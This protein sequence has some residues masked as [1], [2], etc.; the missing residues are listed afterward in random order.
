VNAF[1]E[2]LKKQGGCAWLL[3]AY[4]IFMVGYLIYWF[5][6]GGD[7]EVKQFRDRCT[8]RET[9]RYG[10]WFSDLPESLQFQ[11]IASCEKQL[12]EFLDQRRN[13]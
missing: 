5:A 7:P 10:Q 2:D 3:Y 1:T 4:G 6:S 12:R 13:R 11:I 8:S 9:S